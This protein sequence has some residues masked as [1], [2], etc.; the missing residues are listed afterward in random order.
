M[1]PAYIQTAI[2]ELLNTDRASLF[3]LD[4]Q[5]Q[6]LYAQV[7]SVSDEETS[8]INRV[9]LPQDPSGPLYFKDYVA[10]HG[11]TP[12]PIVAYRGKKVR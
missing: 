3:L 10:N 6:E 11:K 9:S 7:F 5:T 4:D 1:N 8:K 12:I 2:K